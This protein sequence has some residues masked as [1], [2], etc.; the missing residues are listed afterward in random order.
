M[1]ARKY[2]KNKLM[3][4]GKIIAIV[5]VIV[6]VGAGLAFWSSS[7]QAPSYQAPAFNQSTSTATTQTAPANQTATTTVAAVPATAP[8]TVTVTYT[9]N[10]FSPASVTIPQGGTVIWKNMSSSGVRVSSDPHPLHNGYPTTGGCVGSTFDACKSILPGDSWPFTFTFVGSW[11]YH[12]HLNPS[13]RGTVV[14]Q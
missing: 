5:I 14:V 7:M 11:G 3:Q 1:V 13:Q 8:A 6:V 2:N 10:G 12:N 9:D 4:K